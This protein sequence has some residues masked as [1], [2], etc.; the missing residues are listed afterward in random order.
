MTVRYAYYRTKLTINRLVERNIKKNEE[1][2]VL[3]LG[4]V[5]LVGDCS[6]SE[7]RGRSIPDL[8]SLRLGALKNSTFAAL[9]VRIEFLRFSCQVPV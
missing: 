3:S 8:Q 1:A 7:D 4:S 2:R 5:L 9:G 6:H